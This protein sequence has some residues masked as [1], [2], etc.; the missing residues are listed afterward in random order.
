MSKC[1]I[2]LPSK[3]EGYTVPSI[4]HVVH[5]RGSIWSLT[6]KDWKPSLFKLRGGG[7]VTWVFRV[8]HTLVIKIKY[9]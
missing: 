2:P 6:S 3:T 7:G 5:R 1:D 4:G 8:A 9:P